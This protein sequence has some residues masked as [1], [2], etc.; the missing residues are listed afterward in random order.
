[1]VLQCAANNGR[2]EQAEAPASAKRCTARVFQIIDMKRMHGLQS[3]RKRAS[4]VAET[5]VT[6]AHAQTSF[7]YVNCRRAL[8]NFGARRSR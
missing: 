3:S 8:T 2:S 6:D 5:D 1:M 7:F 4:H